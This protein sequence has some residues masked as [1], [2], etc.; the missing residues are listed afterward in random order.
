MKVI[1]LRAELKFVEPGRGCFEGIIKNSEK[2]ELGTVFIGDS[3]ET[4]LSSKKEVEK[5][6]MRTWHD[7]VNDCDETIYICMAASLGAAWTVRTWLTEKKFSGV[8]L[9]FLQMARAKNIN[10]NK[11]IYQIWG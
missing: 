1:F 4:L 3:Y 8:N 6:I 5:S 7:A 2:L 11:K 9:K 10:P